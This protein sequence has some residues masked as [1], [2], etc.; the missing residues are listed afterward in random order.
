MR[1]LKYLIT[2]IFL[3]VFVTPVGAITMLADPADQFGIIAPGPNAV[4]SGAVSTV[5]MAYDDDQTLVPFE[6]ALLDSTL[7]DQKKATIAAGS[8]NSSTGPHTNNWNT[9]GPFLDTAKLVDGAYC[10]EV[11]VSLKNGT[12]PYSACDARIVVIRNNNSA[13]YFT[14]A[15]PVNPSI[16]NAAAWAYDANAAD[17]E[18]DPFSFALAAAPSFVSLNP[19]TGVVSIPAGAKPAGTY[20][21][22]IV[23]RDSLGASSQQNISLTIQAPAPVTPPPPSSTST[24]STTTTTTTTTSQGVEQPVFKFIYP[25]TNSVLSGAE[26]KLKW[27]LSDTEGVS[28]IVLKYRDADGKEIRIKELT[29]DQTEFIWDVSDLKE[30]TY[31]LEATLEMADGTEIDYSSQPFSVKNEI[32]PGELITKPLITDVIPNEGAELRDLKPVI[33]GK[34]TAPIDGTINPESFTFKL[35]EKDFSEICEVTAAEFKCTPQADLALGVHKVEVSIEDFDKQVTTKKWSFTIISADGQVTTT[36]SAG[37]EGIFLGDTFIPRQSI[38]WALLICCAAFLLIAIPWVLWAIWRNRRHEE[39]E[40]AQ[41][42]Y[43]ESVAYSPVE[44][45]PVLDSMQPIGDYTVAATPTTPEVNV[46]YYYPEASSTQENGN[47]NSAEPIFPEVVTATELPSVSSQTTETQTPAADTNVSVNINETTLPATATP[48]TENYVNA[49]PLP[50][51][52]PDQTQNTT[53]TT[54]SGDASQPSWLSPLP[55]AAPASPTSGNTEDNKDTGAFGYGSK[56]D[57]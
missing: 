15:A 51:A 10:M 57:N 24:S 21:I 17:A 28:K 53:S 49:D 2:I 19:T 23:V 55:A 6:L 45:L 30:G 54:T 39:A 14:T 36:S 7:C 3:A 25:A 35:D 18:G 50:I 8:V 20:T 31:T 13:P 42:E 26:N 32:D 11:C 27:E 34:F 37:A 48:N 33:S 9:N 12:T 56:V 1:K 47:I 16:A 46:N 40:A 29:P 52:S 38:I 5:W 43:S 44:P 41:S 22:S 4:V